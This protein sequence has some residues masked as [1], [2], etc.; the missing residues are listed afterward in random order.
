MKKK[1]TLC[2]L[3]DGSGSFPL[4]GMI[5]GIQPIE[6]SEIEPYPIRVT[7]RRLPQVKNYGDVSKLKGDEIEPTDII[8]F[9][10]PCF[11]GKTL[12]KTEQGLIKIKDITTQNTVF[13][14]GKSCKI[15]FAG[16][17]Q[18]NAEVVT[19]YF[20]DGYAVTCT[21]DHRFL[22]STGW[23]EAINLSSETIVK[24]DKGVAFIKKVKKQKFTTPVYDITVEDEHCFPLKNGVIVHNCQ[25]VSL[26]GKRK[27]MSHTLKGD[28]DTTRSGLFFDAIRIIEEMR[29][30]TDGKKPRY[31]CYENVFGI[32]SSREGDDFQRVL[33][34]L[35]Q[36]KDPNVEIPK[37]ESWPHAGEIKGKDFSVAWRI[38]DAQYFG[39]PQRRKRIYLV[40]DFNGHNA[41]KVMFE[42]EGKSFF[43]KEH[44][45]IWREMGEKGTAEEIIKAY[46]EKVDGK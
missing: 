26:A 40:A 15:T 22:T 14:N 13:V 44:Q 21:P 35:C 11:L 38:L 29:S 30:A 42:S 46:R 7:E 23:V 4:A 27:G 2:S 17:T 3:F 31:A 1:L 33:E 19:V 25:D 8:T 9:G 34:E 12:V 18:D 28:E 43:S 37:M 45:K 41:G 24:K 5:C 10:S 6:S 36:I 39:V 16:K 32:F 20:E